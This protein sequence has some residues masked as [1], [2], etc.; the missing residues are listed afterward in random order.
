MKIRLWILSICG[1]IHFAEVFR[2]KNKYVRQSRFNVFLLNL[3]NVVVLQLSYVSESPGMLVETHC[4]ISGSPH[5][6]L[7]VC[8]FVFYQVGLG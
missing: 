4:L 8:L 5:H 1:V 6:L 7:F 2:E 3:F